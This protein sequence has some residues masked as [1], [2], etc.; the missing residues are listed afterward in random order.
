MN[1]WRIAL[2][3]VAVVLCASCGNVIPSPPA[4]RETAS[5]APTI[6]AAA[7]PRVAVASPPAATPPPSPAATPPYQI[8]LDEPIAQEPGTIVFGELEGSPSDIWLT[9]YLPWPEKGYPYDWRYAFGAF[10]GEPVEASKIRITLYRM[11]AGHA[12]TRVVGHKA[13][14]PGCDGL[15]RRTGAVQGTGHVSP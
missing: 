14:D 5:P 8:R 2:V 1:P 9:A 7:T 12:S 13:R 4:V 15:P 10:W 11:T 3:L 6:D